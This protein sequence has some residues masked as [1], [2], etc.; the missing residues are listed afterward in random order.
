MKDLQT[1][2]TELD[3]IDDELVALLLKRAQLSAEVG[4]YK[5]ESKRPVYDAAREAEKLEKL[6]DRAESDLD[7]KMI[8]NVYTQILAHS[9][10]L[11]YMIKEEGTE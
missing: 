10:E 7:K 9:R 6:T 8:A 3:N 5:K 11:Q 4:E 1:I 2:R